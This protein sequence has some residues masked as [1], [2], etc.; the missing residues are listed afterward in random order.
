MVN[1]D[2]E[3]GPSQVDSSQYFNAQKVTKSLTPLEKRYFLA[4]ERGNLSFVKR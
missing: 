2:C 1:Q 4:V 3:A